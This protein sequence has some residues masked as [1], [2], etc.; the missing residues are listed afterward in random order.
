[1]AVRIAEIDAVSA[2]LPVVAPFDC[3]AARSE[4]RFPARK[5]LLADRKRHVQHALPA[6]PR[7]GPARQDDGLR[8]GALE[9][10][11]EDIVP[12]HGIAGQAVVAVDRLEPEHVFVEGPRARHVL[13]VDRGFQ[14]AIE[15]RHSYPSP[16]YCRR[17]IAISSGLPGT[18]H[19]PSVLSQ[20]DG[21]SG[22]YR[23]HSFVYKGRERS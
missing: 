5:L 21:K 10:D 20:T 18:I 8:R 12:R 1:M 13:G 16:P 19:R 23:R 9:E 4:M 7:N 3:H 11:Q 6:M 15:L 2:A 22:D 17:P 14:D